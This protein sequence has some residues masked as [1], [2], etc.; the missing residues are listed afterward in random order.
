MV[1]GF[2]ELTI[3]LLI[4]GFCLVWEFIG[5]VAVWGNYCSGTGTGGS[6]YF[7][8]CNDV[9]LIV[10]LVISFLVFLG[11]TRLLKVKQT[12]WTTKLFFIGL[13]VICVAASPFVLWDLPFFLT[14]TYK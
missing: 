14:S 5:Y 1:R 8:V 7:R 9:W 12:S 13:Y 4:C 11:M 6:R 2:L 10:I 3:Y